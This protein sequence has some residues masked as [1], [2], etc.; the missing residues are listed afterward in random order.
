MKTK[1]IDTI[2]TRQI[3]DH[4]SPSVQY[5]AFDKD[6]VIHRFQYGFADVKNQ[7][8]TTD[9]TTYNAY[10]VTKT[11]T[12]LA[13]LQL[14]SQKRL[15]ISDSIKD[16]LPDFPYSPD[17]TIHQ[18]MT[19]TAGIPNPIPLSW[20]HLK[21]EHASFDRT[22]FFEQILKKNSK[23]KSVPNEKFAYSNLGYVFLGQLIEKISGLSYEEYIHANILDPLGIDRAQLNF[24]VN[25]TTPHAKGY[26]KKYSFSNAILGFFFDK[27]KFIGETEGKWKPF[28]DNYVNGAS[29]GG[30]IGTSDAFAKYVQELLTPD[31]KLLPDNYKSILF[32][33]NS[34]NSDKPTGMC[35]S[36]FSGILNGKQYY[37]HAGGGGGYY[38]EMRIYPNIGIGSVIMFNRTGMR[39]ER[40]LDKL[41][42]FIIDG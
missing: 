4:T 19:H 8:K 24:I 13:V 12:A 26:I 29:Y 14:M 32:S 28:N 9:K 2:L 39:D 37:T 22:G 36:W 6:S 25:D 35:L 34:T 5:I 1:E 30:L 16:Y 40:F 20:I 21:E 27:S 11:F 33:E 18:L 10:S 42:K 17:I 23:L 7:V 38:C 31:C 15:N 41:D 3:E